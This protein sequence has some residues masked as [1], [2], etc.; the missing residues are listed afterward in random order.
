LARRDS[1]ETIPRGL[2][3]LLNRPWDRDKPTAKDWAE[4]LAALPLFANVSKRHLRGIA[5]L[6]KFKEF[7]PGDVVIQAG[8]PPDA[9]YL[10]LSGRAKVLGMPR[11]RVL[12]TGDYFGEM[13]LIDGEPRSATITAEGELQAMALP[14]RPFLRLLKREPGIALAMLAELAGRVRRLE[15]TAVA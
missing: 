10:I 1:S 3:R 13:G 8:E 14:R 7:D 15:K 5:K 2:A 11:T 6:A 12:R 4:V 9:F